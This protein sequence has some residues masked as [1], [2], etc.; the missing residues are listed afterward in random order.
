M[1]SFLTKTAAFVATATSVLATIAATTNPVQAV[2]VNFSWN[3]N[4]GYSATGSFIYDETKAPTF[5]SESG[6][7]LTKFLQSFSISFL[8]PTQK[9]LESG[10]AVVNGV[11]SDKFLRLDF[12]ST[13]KN[14]SV[15]DGDI[16]GTYKYFL[17]NLRTPD[18]NRVG[19]GITTFNF[20]DRTNA[21]VALDISPSVQVV[22]AGPTIPSVPEPTMTLGTLVA[23]GLSIALKRKKQGTSEN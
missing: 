15:L 19:P 9:V 14:I 6:A 18:G 10:S 11:S 22:G 4:Q 5:I 2:Q 21:D 16:G 1:R 8:D 23:G 17:T 3:G 7:G 20:F 12:D 13:S